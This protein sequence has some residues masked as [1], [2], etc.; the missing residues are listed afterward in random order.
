V[1]ERG[2]IGSIL[3]LFRGVSRLLYGCGGCFIANQKFRAEIDRALALAADGKFVPVPE[4]RWSYDADYLNSFVSLAAKGNTNFGKS[5][6]ALY[7]RPTLL[8]IDV[9]F[10]I[11]YASFAV[12]FWLGVLM[13]L[14]HCPLI[15]SLSVFCLV[16]A[17]LYGIADV[18]EDLWLV[19]LFSQTGRVS[20]A[21]GAIAC[22]LTR[23]KIVT[24]S[25]RPLAV[26][27][28]CF[29]RRSSPS[30]AEILTGSDPLPRFTT[31]D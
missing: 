3:L 4:R 6:L 16:M 2:T 5:A 26:C 31:F 27:F 20:G 29:C 21:Q 23:T 9:C 8:W 14:L 17:G 18:A 22:K 1:T 19:K 24:I 25:L 28:F 10:A 15:E 7:I 12:L 13:R 30:G 11:F